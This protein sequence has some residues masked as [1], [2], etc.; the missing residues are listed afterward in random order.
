[1]SLS[2]VRLAIDCGIISDFDS[3]EYVIFRLMQQ[4]KQQLAILED[5]FEA[6]YE[7]IEALMKQQCIKAVTDCVENT[8]ILFSEKQ[9][10]RVQKKAAGYPL[11]VEL[12]VASRG[13]GRPTKPKPGQAVNPFQNCIIKPKL[14]NLNQLSLKQL[15][16]IVD[17]IN[18]RQYE[19]SQALIDR[20]SDEIERSLDSSNAV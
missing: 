2:T 17:A 1:M 18:K 12:L 13:R 14:F 10:K 11:Q 6:S 20:I 4:A 5:Y 7:N 3:L 19:S 15:T 16:M 9:K 8:D